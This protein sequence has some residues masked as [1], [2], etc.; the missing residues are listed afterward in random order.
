MYLRYVSH[1]IGIYLHYINY[2]YAIIGLYMK[3][4]LITEFIYNNYSKSISY[5]HFHRLFIKRTITLL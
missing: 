2:I 5:L 3:D 1:Y 4:N